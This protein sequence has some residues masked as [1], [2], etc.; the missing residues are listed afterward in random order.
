M[1]DLH[2]DQKKEAFLKYLSFQID[3]SNM[4]QVAIASELGYK[5]PNIITMFKQGTT[6]VPLERVAKFATILGVDKTRLFRMA[7]EAQ[8]KS[9]LLDAMDEISPMNTKNESAILD[10]IREGTHGT[11]P[12][13][14][15]KEQRDALDAFVKTLYVSD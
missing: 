15:T 7:C 5:K 6:S 11:D 2:L 10:C 9:G 14:S 13:V 4:T 8:G 12:R 3:N 1:S